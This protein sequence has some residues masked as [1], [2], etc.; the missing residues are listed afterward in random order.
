MAASHP[1][2]KQSQHSLPLAAQQGSCG[3]QAN[4]ALKA[5]SSHALAT[6]G[7]PPSWWP[8]SCPAKPPPRPH[9][10]PDHG[11]AA[12]NAPKHSLTIRTSSTMTPCHTAWRTDACVLNGCLYAARDAARLRHSAHCSALPRQ[13]GRA[14]AQETCAPSQQQQLAD[15]DSPHSASESVPVLSRA[16]A[17]AADPSCSPLAA[18]PGAC[19][20]ACPTALATGEGSPPAP[21]RAAPYAA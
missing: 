17:S 16:L 2:P 21:A 4:P 10:I 20:S 6:S 12:A 11:Y 18:Y 7:L 15:N 14:S 13:T 9:S 3:L 5:L 19:T 8:C 1:E